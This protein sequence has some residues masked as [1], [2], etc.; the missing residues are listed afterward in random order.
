VR[1]SVGVT[2]LL[3]CF[4][5]HFAVADSMP[6]VS[7]ITLAD[8]LFLVSYALT[9]LSHRFR[10]AYWLDTKGG[11]SLAKA[12]HMERRRLPVILAAA[13]SLQKAWR[14]T[15]RL[16]ACHRSGIAPLPRRTW[17][18]SEPTLSA[19]QNVRREARTGTYRQSSTG[20]AFGVGRR[21]AIDHQRLA[22]ILADA[23]W[24]SRGAQSQPQVVRRCPLTADDLLFA[25]QVSP[26]LGSS[27]ARGQPREL[28][29]RFADRITAATDSI[30]SCR[31]M[32]LKPSSSA[33]DTRRSDLP[34]NAATPST[35]PYRIASS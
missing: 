25:L 5:F 14:C 15:R 2:A 8:V 28:V 32:R 24:R 35:G 34:Q 12:G 7:Y 1:A 17:S 11:A 23:S 29:V 30:T 31:G 13:S 16:G 19:R 21:R 6:S 3:A 20:R 27:N 10:D 9:Q 26:D 33:V 4:A 18:A 22:A